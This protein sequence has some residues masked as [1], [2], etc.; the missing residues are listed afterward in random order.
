[1]DPKTA[2]GV[3]Y[4]VPAHA[5]FDWLALR[6][7][8]QKPE[9][10]KDFTWMLKW[11]RRLSP[12]HLSKWKVTATSQQWRSLQQM[13]IKDQHDP[14]ADEATKALY[15]KEFHSGILK[16][17]CGPYAG[18]TVREVKETLIRDFK[19]LGVADTMYDLPEP[20]VCR[21]MTP[22]IVKVLSDQWFLNYSDPEWKAKAKQAV[23]SDADLP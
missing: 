14:K 15:K 16:E 23:G 2:T 3:V 19:G 1:M 18:K 5:P 12:F 10:L 11:L 9:V 4:S 8:Q 17:N 13:G 21:C 22:C 6:D 20:V 7:L